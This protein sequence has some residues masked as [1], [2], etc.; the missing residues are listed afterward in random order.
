MNSKQKFKIHANKELFDQF[1]FMADVI[2]DAAGIVQNDMETTFPMIDAW[3]DQAKS[4]Q[5]Q[6]S[7]LVKKTTDYIKK[8]VEYAK[9][10]KDENEESNTDAEN[11]EPPSLGS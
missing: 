9:L 8:E 11:N 10:Y 3:L 7:D 2:R 6:L 5:Q 1:R 4:C